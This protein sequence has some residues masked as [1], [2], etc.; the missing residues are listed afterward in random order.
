MFRYTM[1][2]VLLVVVSA[3]PASAVDTLQVRSPDPVLEDWRWTAYDRT[4][5]LAGPMRDVFEDRDG[6]MWF[7]TDMGAQRYDG[8]HWT[9]YTTDDGLAHNIVRTVIQDRDGAMWFGT[10]G[11]GISRFDGK[12]WTTYTTDDGLAGNSIW[13]R[14]LHQAPDGTIWAGFRAETDTSGTQNGISR[15]DGKT[16][17]TIEVPVGNPRPSISDI[18]TAADGSLWFT[19]WPD[20]GVLRFDGAD[21]TQFTPAEGLAGNGSLDI[22]ESRDGSLWVTHYSNG[23]S[24]FDGKRWRTYISR[25][26]L[27][28]NVRWVILW[29]TEDGTIWASGAGGTLCRFDG[30]RW[31]TYTDQETPRFSGITIAQTG[32]DGVVWF[33]DWGRQMVHRLA[34]SSSRKRVFSFEESFLGGQTTPDGSMWFGARSGAVRYNGIQWLRYTAADGL[35]DAPVYAMRKTDN[36]SLWFFGGERWKFRGLSRYDNGT[37]RRYPAE[38]VGLDDA[39]ET[40]QTTDGAFWVIGTRAGGSAASRF[41][42]RTWRVYT[43]DDGLVGKYLS[44]ILQA[45]N[46]DLWFAT[47]PRNKPG[48][49]SRGESNGILRFDGGR[50]TSYTTEDGLG[51]NRVYNLFQSPDGTLWASTLTTLD[52]FDGTAWH[53]AAPVEELPN[54]K[55]SGF[56]MYRDA[57][58]FGHVDPLVLGA[59]R[60]DGETWKTYTTDDGLVDNRVRG[61]YALGDG[62]LWLCTE[63]GVSKFDGTNWVNYTVA[64]GLPSNYLSRVWEAADG[65]IWL[66]ST[67]GKVGTFTPDTAGPETD[68]LPASKQ[69][70]SV[71]NILL[72]WSGRDP[73]DDTVPQDLRYQ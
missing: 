28:E 54:Y 24:R 62:N 61:A 63:G 10:Y 37:W 60:F 20:G 13:G 52:R 51:H 65:T 43:T 6:N 22:F 12:T 68:I 56:T 40:L 48:G 29:Q 66:R 7:A 15:F 21:W 44:N 27:P 26:G 23:I 30:E 73:W 5:G 36:G 3:S 16:W 58:W 71:G 35:L 50:W 55:P 70:S 38:E 14:G 49:S 57:L 69:V 19:C 9:T 42:E 1:T 45:Q 53:K 47:R 46:G 32:R 18:H 31:K 8:S 11:G 2:L 64:D 4:S 25:D 67:D 41:D 72:R 34:Y 33:W 17:T 59:T 39:G